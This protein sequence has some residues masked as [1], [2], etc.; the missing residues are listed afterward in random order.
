MCH[1]TEYCVQHR[2]GTEGRSGNSISNLW[3]ISLIKTKLD[4]TPHQW[5]HS[6][7]Y[8]RFDHS[9]KITSHHKIEMYY[10]VSIK[11]AP[12]YMYGCYWEDSVFIWHSY[13]KQYIVY[14]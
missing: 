12:A 4:P 13:L 3:I 5:M 8:A 6:M 7:V 11:K 14:Q 9:Q 2:H 1:I 10:D